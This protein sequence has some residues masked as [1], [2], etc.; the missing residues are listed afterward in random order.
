MRP[1]GTRVVVV[2]TGLGA[3]LVLIRYVAVGDVG[4]LVDAAVALVFLVALVVLV[5]L[6]GR[7]AAVL[8]D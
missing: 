5:A 4:L 6:V 2:V 3:V 8:L 7:A 1:T